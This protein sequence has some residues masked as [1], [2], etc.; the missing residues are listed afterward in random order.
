MNV[1]CSVGINS[2]LQV[3]QPGDLIVHDP[4][5]H[6][7]SI[8]SMDYRDEDVFCLTVK[9]AEHPTTE[10]FFDRFEW[11]LKLQTN[12]DLRLAHFRGHDP[13]IRTIVARV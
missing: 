4:E 2:Y 8:Q 12:G 1:L 10:I 3:L 11:M 9:V 13:T 5:K 7:V 6:V